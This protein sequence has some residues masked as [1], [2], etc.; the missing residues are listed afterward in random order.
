MDEI[1]DAMVFLLENTA[2]NGVDLNVDWRLA[3]PVG[4]RFRAHGGGRAAT[5]RARRRGP[6][7]CQISA[8][9]INGRGSTC[10]GPG[11][12]AATSTQG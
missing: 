11:V 7:C 1:V 8:R 10:R 5:G 9:V 2:V 3:L 4:R 12:W 6:S